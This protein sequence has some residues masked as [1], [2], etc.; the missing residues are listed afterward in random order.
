[1]LAEGTILFLKD[2]KYP[3]NLFQSPFNSTYFLPIQ[4]FNKHDEHGHS[5]FI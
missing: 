3:F 4:N 1:M 5:K 2:K